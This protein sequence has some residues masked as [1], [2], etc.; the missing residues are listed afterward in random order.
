MV[1]HKRPPYIHVYKDRHGKERIY[2]NRPG[3]QK[4]ALPEPLYSEAFWSAYHK[5][6]DGVPQCI[7][8]VG[9]S[10][11]VKG[12]INDLIAR[13]Y[14]SA[15]FTSKAAATQRNYKSVLEPFRE[16]YG[17]GPV[18]GI[19]TKHIDAIIGG[20]ASRSTSAAHNL[21][22]RLLLIFGLAVKWEFREDNPVILADR[23]QHKTKSYET[24]SKEDIAK[25]RAYWKEGTPQRIAMEILLYTGLRR[26]DAV[27]LGLQHIQGGHITITAQK[28]GAKLSIPIHREFLDILDTIPNKHLTFITTERGAARSEKAFTNWISEA[29]RKAGLPAH[30]SP[31]GLRKAACV[32]LADAGCDAFEI[33][34]I[35]GHSDIKE[36]Q[37]YVA[38]ANKK[39]AA[40][41][42]I[43]KAYG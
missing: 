7:K 31:H 16:K 1:K 24:W 39:Q 25:F 2:F 34:A 37:T 21:R 38:A 42:A 33:M 12:T 40:K 15:G 36:V 26:S 32:R 30:R 3:T 9:A 20:V 41:N 18:A 8:S 23:V 22:K 6:K 17:D 11:V 10:K 14:A 4:T 13:Y 28:T 35:T 29:A 43:K 5:A 27:R 19:K